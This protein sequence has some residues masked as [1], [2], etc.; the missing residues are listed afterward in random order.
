MPEMYNT[1]CITQTAA[2]VAALMRFPAPAAAAEPIPVVLEAAQ[3]RFG[4]LPVERMLLYNPDAI[5]M[6]L[7]QKYTPAFSGVMLHSCLT[8]PVRSVM[9]SVTPVC[10]ASMYTG[11]MP[12]VHGIRAYEKPVLKCETLFDA[13][14]AAGHRVAIVSTEG[15]SISQIFLEREMDYYILPTPQDCNAKAAELMERDACDLLVLY[16]RNYDAT[17]HRNGPESE[18]SLEELKR[19]A[20][21]LACFEQMARRVWRGKRAAMAFL[22]DHGCH[23]IDGGMGS[24]GLDMAEDMNIV[25]FYHFLPQ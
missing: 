12:E 25:H 13:A 9:P 6:W 17:M 14:I 10:F 19:N 23:E 4:A 5:A 15:D 16:N 7:F 22:P 20:D 21:T 24:H 3:N 1:T 2:T 18:R 11:V 8:I